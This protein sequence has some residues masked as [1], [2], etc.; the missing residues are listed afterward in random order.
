MNIYNIAEVNTFESFIEIEQ[1]N[2]ELIENAIMYSNAYKNKSV[3]R[4]GVLSSIKDLIVSIISKIIDLFKKFIHIFTGNSKE[5][6]KKSEIDVKKMLSKYKESDMDGVSLQIKK[7]NVD[8]VDISPVFE[9]INS[10]IDGVAASMNS[11]N[12]GYREGNEDII[13][14]HYI[15]AEREKIKDRYTVLVNSLNSYYDSMLSDQETECTFS[16]IKP[17]YTDQQKIE[18]QSTDNVKEMNKIISELKQ[19]RN[20]AK[21]LPDDINPNSVKL[22]QVK[23]S[24]MQ[25]GVQAILSSY[26]SLMSKIN[27]YYTNIYSKMAKLCEEHTKGE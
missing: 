14:T 13:T 20:T 7:L 27:M 1:L 6:S 8:S 23:L 4:E 25:N 3:L 2:Q 18:K 21:K 15:S 17:L 26:N 24:E 19:Y 9:E 10:M 12:S 5:V 16:M 11:I 22:I